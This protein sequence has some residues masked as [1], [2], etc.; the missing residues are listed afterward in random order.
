MNEKSKQRA[1]RGL[2]VLWACLFMGSL[3]V[4][5]NGLTAEQRVQN[6]AEELME[7]SRS[8]ETLEVREAKFCQMIQKNMDFQGMVNTLL[9]IYLRKAPSESVETFYAI[10]PSFAF[11]YLKRISDMKDLSVEIK[12]I[13]KISSGKYILVKTKFIE[14]NTPYKISFLLSIQE[15]G[16]LLIK[17]VRFEGVSMLLTYRQQF[18]S[19]LQHLRRQNTPDPV[20]TLVE[21][22]EAKLTH[23]CPPH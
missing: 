5:A 17:D 11:H 4:S 22:V 6:M 13:H 1:T 10:A 23:P 15:G 14:K 9:G 2:W 8:N 18:Q 19:R 16:E 20:L 3:A 12:S 21:E 7:L